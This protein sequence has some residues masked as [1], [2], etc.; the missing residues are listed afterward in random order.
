MQNRVQKTEYV[1]MTAL[2]STAITGRISAA[3]RRVVSTVG[4]VIVAVFSNSVCEAAAEFQQV[5]PGLYFY[6]DF[7]GTNSAVLITDDGVLI[8]DTG[9][10]PD[11]AELI[12]AEIRKH[13]DAPIR[14]VVNSQFHGDHY[15]GNVV[16][17]RE[18]ATFIAHEDTVAVIRE[19]FQLEVESRPFAARGQ[20]PAEVVL[21]LPD[22]EFDRR[23]RLQ[24]GGR[25]IELIYLGAGQNPGDTLVYFPHARALHS[26]GVFHNQSWANTSYTPSYEGWIEV[27][28]AMAAIDVDVYLPPHGPLATAA[29]LEAFTQFIRALTAGVRVA[30]ETGMSLDEMLQTLVFDQ[31]SDWRGYERRERNLTAMYEFMSSGK[32]QFFVPGARAQP[33]SKQ[34]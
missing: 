13:T 20:D 28:L 25:V 7:G 2:P 11:D 14:Y 5:G 3:L 8:V 32:A 23:M 1:R 22:I 24:L 33:V 30:V 31:Y 21:V 15:M 26:G 6:Y 10:H 27:L 4:L 16:F 18:G 19:R 29:D 17:Q 12:L 34:K 9:M